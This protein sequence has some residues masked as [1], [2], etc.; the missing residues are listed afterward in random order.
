MRIF[1]CGDSFTENLYK[2]EINSIDF[3]L[4]IDIKMLNK[5]GIEG[6]IN[7][8]LRLINDSVFLEQTLKYQKNNFIRKIKNGRIKKL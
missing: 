5:K 8:I 2:T 1:L 7:H 4:G 6:E 3:L